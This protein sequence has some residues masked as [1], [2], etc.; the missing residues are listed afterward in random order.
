ASEG[1]LFE[2]HTLLG[3]PT[4]REVTRVRKEG[5]ELSRIRVDLENGMFKR[6]I[7]YAN[8]DTDRIVQADLYTHDDRPDTE[9]WA[10]IR[11]DYPERV[12]PSLFRFDPPKGTPVR[13][14]DE[15]LTLP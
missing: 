2:G 6:M 11:F 3:D 7:V 14:G 5:R 9:P 15:D 10:R 8:L 1:R 4:P 12:P 13:G